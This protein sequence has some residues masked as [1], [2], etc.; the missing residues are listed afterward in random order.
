MAQARI[1]PHREATPDAVSWGAWWVELNGTRLEAEAALHG[2]DYATPVSFEIQPSIAEGEFLQS[3]GQKSLWDCEAVAI[4]ECAA[5]GHRFSARRSLGELATGADKMLVVTP[6]LGS[7]ADK[8]VLTA[9]VVVAKDLSPARDD[10]AGRRGARLHSSSRQT[11]TLEGEGARFPTDAVPF[12]KLRLPN[13][14]WTVHT[15]FS[16]LEEPFT[17][18]VRLLINTE[19]VR[20]DALVDTTHPDHALLQSALE[21]DLV[22][23]LLRAATDEADKFR[24]APRTWPEGSTGAA[25]E[26]MTELFFG[27]SVH[28]LVAM[29]RSDPSAFSRL[30]HARLDL[31]GGSK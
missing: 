23:Q 21:T 30:L 29:E 14:L 2:W 1:L 4:V 3:T 9:Q 20:S 13:S 22:R 18:S 15:D 11:V 27:D 5:T 10:V 25:L 31:F 19:H 17:N 26:A 28:K 8:V 7:I 16:D 6:P 24:R 12:S